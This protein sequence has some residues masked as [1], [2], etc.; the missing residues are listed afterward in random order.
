MRIIP[1]QLTDYQKEILLSPKRFTI[2]EAA[3]KCGKTFSHIWWLFYLAHTEQKKEGANYWWVAPVYEQ[4]EIAF[5]R[6]VSKIR[7]NKYYQINHSKL[8]IVCPNG[9]IM[10]FKSADNPDNLY[11]EDV[12]AAVFDEF[13]RA[14]YEAWVALR[15]TLTA[16]NGK[17]KLIGNF[18]GISNWGHRLAEK[19]KDVESEYQYFKIT[20]WD[21]VASGILKREEIE[22]AQKDL[23]APIFAALYLAEA[24]EDRTQ[25]IKNSKILEIFTNSFAEAGQMY[26]SA[27]VAFLND[28]AVLAVWNGLQI[29]DALV[30]RGI[31]A[32]E[33][34]RKIL[35]LE[36]IY[37]IPRTNIIYDSDGL[38][39]YLRD[40]LVGAVAF[41][42]NHSAGSPEYANIKIRLY[43]MLADYISNNK[44]YVKHQ[45]DEQTKCEL[46]EELQ[47]IKSKE[48]DTRYGLLSKKEVK[49]IIGRS[50]DITD[51]LMM[52]MFYCLY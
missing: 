27:D 8:L 25:I 50:P 33:L 35:E 49:E 36:Q 47:C 44:I 13:T 46:I 3:T 5:K 51:S 41:N 2:T 28:R 19:A 45:F 29:V 21:A 39:N 26:L 17:C 9:N 22:Q 1:P 4:A 42:N 15:S 38:G 11:G 14:K 12:Y 20:A 7:N 31:G 30:Y 48:S 43:Y 10:R 34:L 24:L 16:T 37:K 40:S 23:P 18:T 6:I 32:A 52:R